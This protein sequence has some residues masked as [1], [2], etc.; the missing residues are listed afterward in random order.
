MFLSREFL[1][2][3]F[4]VSLYFSMGI[5]MAYLLI[6]AFGVINSRTGVWLFSIYYN[7]PFNTF[8]NHITS[9]YINNR[10]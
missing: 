7:W 9:K 4:S 2:I 8:K 10:L 3:N 1:C 5:D 6:H